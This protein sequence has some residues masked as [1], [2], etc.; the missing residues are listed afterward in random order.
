MSDFVAPLYLYNLIVLVKSHAPAARTKG[1]MEL[2]HTSQLQIK[3]ILETQIILISLFLI[4]YH[5]VVFL[6]FSNI[7]YDARETDWR[8]I[9]PSHK[10]TCSSEPAVTSVLCKKT[11]V[12]FIYNIRGI[13][14]C[15][16]DNGIIALY[17]V[18]RMY[19]L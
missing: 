3:L 18:L 6:F 8:T 4:L 2:F 13:I 17:P 10:V 1:H 11:Y 7:K 14:H 15:Q 12:L 19:Q 16:I 5:L 9:R